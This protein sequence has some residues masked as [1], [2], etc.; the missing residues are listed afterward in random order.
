LIDALTILFV[1][2]ISITMPDGTISDPI[3]LVFANYGNIYCKSQIACFI[4]AEDLYSFET[5]TIWHN[6]NYWDEKD[7]CGRSPVQHEITHFK[8]PNI[9]IHN[10]CEYR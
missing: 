6:L 5:N 8:Y 9:D 3:D 1:I 10:E 7:N 4:Y 2:T